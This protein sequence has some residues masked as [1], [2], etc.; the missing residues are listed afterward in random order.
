VSGPKILAVQ[1]KYY[2]DDA[3]M[4]PSWRALREHFATATT[5]RKIV[6]LFIAAQADCF[7][8]QNGQPN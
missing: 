6:G 7:H 8:W 5:N 1:F 2:D 3:L 4:T